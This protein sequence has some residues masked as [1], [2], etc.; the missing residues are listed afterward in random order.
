MDIISHGRLEFGLGAGGVEREHTAYGTDFLTAAERIRRLGEVCEI[1]RR[2]WAE[3]VVNFEGRYYHLSETYCE[4]KPIQK[5]HPPSSLVVGVSSSPCAWSRDMLMFGTARASHIRLLKSF[6]TGAAS[7]MALVLKLDATRQRLRA[8]HKS[9][10]IL[11][12]I[13]QR[14][15]RLSKASLRQEQRIWSWP[16]ALA[17]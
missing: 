2:M 5:P 13:Q 8:P 1:I 15:A 12:R 9:P 4:P 7:S 6:N 16:L 10:L 11:R 17:R 14:S 3:P